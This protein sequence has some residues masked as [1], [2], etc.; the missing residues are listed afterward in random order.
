MQHTNVEKASGGSLFAR[1]A[2][3]ICGNFLEMFD[4]FVYGFYA[5]II[6]KVLFPPAT[7]ISPSCC[8]GS[9]SASAS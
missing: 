7:N 5:S 2:R 3:V 8:P 9:P 4:F 6:A 1:V